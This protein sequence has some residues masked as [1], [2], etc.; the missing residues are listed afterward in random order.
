MSNISIR[1]RFQI[2]SGLSQAKLLEKIRTAL[3]QPDAPVKGTIIDHHVIL[4]IPVA[5]QHY[6]S[7]QLDLEIE[8]TEKRTV[9]KGLFGPNPSVWFMYIFFYSVLSF[10]SIMVLIMGFCLKNSLE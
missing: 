1:P 5:H 10:V 8:E 7:P 4:R 3:E 9:I 6:W 2:P